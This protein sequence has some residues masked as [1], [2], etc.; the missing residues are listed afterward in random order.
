MAS[1]AYCSL[2]PPSALLL[3]ARSLIDEAVAIGFKHQNELHG[4]GHALFTLVDKAVNN[5]DIAC[6]IQILGD[7]VPHLA[8]LLPLTS[9]K[10][11]CEATRAL[12]V[13][14][15]SLA[16]STAQILDKVW[17]GNYSVYAEEYASVS[18]VD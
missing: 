7:L 17:G 11:P 9:S 12:F 8:P 14:L 1:N 5:Q 18:Y 3:K 2:V 15:F 13:R 16:I 6:A 10:N 4:I